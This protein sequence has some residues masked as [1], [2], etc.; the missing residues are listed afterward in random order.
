MIPRR[1]DKKAVNSILSAHGLF[2]LSVIVLAAGCGGKSFEAIR[3]GI[4]ARGHYIGG[5]PFFRQ[6]GD[7]CGPAALAGILAFYGKPVDLKTITASIY[8][9][10]LRGT[11]PMDLERYAKD[12]GLKTASSDGTIDALRSAV[13]SN[14]PAIC[15]LDLGFGPYRQPHYVTIIGFDDE[16]GLFIMH[17]GATPDRTMSYE[18][19]EK[20]WVRAGRWMIVIRP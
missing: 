6:T 10:K 13:R 17:D 19:F 20:K 16:N 11:L 2:L 14:T 15:L 4:E 9:P 12:A 8:L 5:V 18:A 7:D 3:P 1:K